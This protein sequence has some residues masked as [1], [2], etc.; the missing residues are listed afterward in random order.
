MQMK[1]FTI[2]YLVI[3]IV[4]LI[5]VKTEELGSCTEY[6]CPLPLWVTQS[7]HRINTPYPKETEPSK[8]NEVNSAQGLTQKLDPKPPVQTLL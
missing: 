8:T 4:I 1:L 5:A 3:K 6:G 2:L 7:P